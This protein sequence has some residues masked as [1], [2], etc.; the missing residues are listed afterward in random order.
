MPAC[1]EADPGDASDATA[2]PAA[3]RMSAMRSNAMKMYV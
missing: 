1:S 2:P 3:C